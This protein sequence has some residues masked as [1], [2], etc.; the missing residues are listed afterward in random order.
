MSFVI[1]QS[2][3]I[4]SLLRCHDSLVQACCH[5]ATSQAGSSRQQSSRSVNPP[6]ATELSCRQARIRNIEIRRALVDSGLLLGPPRHSSRDH[7]SHLWYNSTATAEDI[8]I[9]EER[10]ENED[11]RAR[12]REREERRR[13]RRELR[14]LEEGVGLPTYTEE[15]VEGESRL[16]RTISAGTVR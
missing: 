5:R 1:Q 12:R 11:R 7:P 14:D 8:L 10:Q 16:E 13:R 9:S 6:H 3:D 2:L 4:V 15:P